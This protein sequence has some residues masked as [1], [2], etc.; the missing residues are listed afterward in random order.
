MRINI[1]NKKSLVYL[2][3]IIC[4]IS[5]LTPFVF[6]TESYSSI[7]SL[8]LTLVGTVATVLTLIIGL[9]ILD[10]YGVKSK[11]KER[12]MEN[13][14][15]I[16]ETLRDMKFSVQVENGYYYI[17]ALDMK[18]FIESDKYLAAKDQLMAFKGYQ[19]LAGFRTWKD[20]YFVPDSI[21]KELEFLNIFTAF[22]TPLEGQ[23]YI[24]M[25]I[26]G[27]KDEIWMTP[28]SRITVDE[29]LKK[30]QILVV[31]VEKQIEEYTVK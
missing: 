30:L 25:Y 12:E 4:I 28:F 21:K 13:V 19:T 15:Q 16:L 20:S 5:F 22:T 9:I 24:R 10:R 26:L 6:N 18:F 27:T 1:R 31:A 7:L 2:T 29:F 23:E 11:F 17:T 14:F 3:S 8:A